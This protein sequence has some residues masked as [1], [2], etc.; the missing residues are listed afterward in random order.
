MWP[1]PNHHRTGRAS[2]AADRGGGK[3]R[4]TGIC[5]GK[6][7]VLNCQKLEPYTTFYHSKV[8]TLPYFII[9]KLIKFEL[10]HILSFKN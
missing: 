5:F 3:A 7:G 6:M 4:K 1:V 2:L 8:G 10:Y 9:Q